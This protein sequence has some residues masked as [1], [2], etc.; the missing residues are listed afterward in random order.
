MAA[1]EANDNLKAPPVASVIIP[2]R[3][4]KHELI[5]VLDSVLQQSVPVEVLVMDDA[6]ADG[7]CELIRQRYPQVRV[8]VGEQ[9]KGPTHRR[10]R[11]AEL[12]TTDYL[13]TLDDDCRLPSAD[14]IAQTIAAFDHP[15]IGAVTIPFI[16]VNTDDQVESAAPDAEGRYVSGRFLGGMIAFRR[17]V[18]QHV[19]GYRESFFMHV[20]ESDL[21]IRM[22]AAGYVIR[23][24][25][26]PPIHHHA[27]PIR[28]R[29][30]IRALGPR[31]QIL[32]AWHNVPM[33]YLPA[34][35]LGNT[36][37]GMLY[38]VRNG[39]IF[40][41]ALGFLRGYANIPRNLK[42]RRP[43]PLKIYRLQRRLSA[44]GAVSFDE[45][46]KQCPH[47]FRM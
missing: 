34:H 24:G 15:R 18:Y 20:E 25:S 21:A 35:A 26:A 8:E 36:L 47:L 23:L 38:G 16:N 42:H 2:T 28:N 39:H 22:L 7:T 29:N 5:A 13:V 19:N 40:A 32:Y 41:T 46:A 45:V 12:A 33:L 9:A 1:S 44:N 4:R 37:K 10:N 11:G 30:R 27:S 31:N 17:D 3:D 14:T 43:V 6:S